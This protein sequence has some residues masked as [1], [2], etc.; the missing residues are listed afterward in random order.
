MY[1]ILNCNTS[2]K[3]HTDSRAEALLYAMLS[4]DY[5]IYLSEG[6]M[7]PLMRYEI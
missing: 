5:S 3:W 4:A 7:R 1:L 2:R 6:G